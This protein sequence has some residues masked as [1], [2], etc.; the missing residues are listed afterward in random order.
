[1][2]EIAVETACHRAAEWT[3]AVRLQKGSWES[4]Y[5]RHHIRFAMRFP[6]LSEK[7]RRKMNEE[8]A[9]NRFPDLDHQLSPSSNSDDSLPGE[10]TAS[11]RENQTVSQV[12]TVRRSSPNV[13]GEPS[14]ILDRLA[15]MQADFENARKRAVKEQQEFR[16]Y[17]LFD[18]VK[19]LL[20]VLDSFERA[21]RVSSSQNTDF[22]SGI[23]LIYMQ[24]LDALV[25]L[26][27][28]PIHATGEKF[29]PTI[30]Y[31]VQV[32]DTHEVKDQLVLEEL[33]RGYKFKDRLLRPAMVSVANNPR[34]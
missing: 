25:K 29:D 26:G 5:R 8:I 17:A 22:R 32:I 10:L 4:Q 12:L 23:E 27:V 31:A 13:E 18:A 16:E 15:R 1:L 30:H 28:H 2:N 7:A 24:V 19:S 34:K 11:A 21:L 3:L 33:Q 6:K 9:T 14:Q 20:P